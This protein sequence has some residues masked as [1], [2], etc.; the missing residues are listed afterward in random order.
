MPERWFRVELRRSPDGARAMRWS[1]TDDAT[2][3]EFAARMLSEMPEDED[4][5]IASPAR[6]M[7]EGPGPCP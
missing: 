6:E 4:W 3:E 1:A 2:P 5:A 7:D